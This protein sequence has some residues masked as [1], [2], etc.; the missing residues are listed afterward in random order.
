MNSEEPPQISL[1]W[2]ISLWIAA[3]LIATIATVGGWVELLIY[4]WIFPWGLLALFVP[5]DWDPP[6][7]DWL[8]LLMAWAL[9]VALTIIGLLQKRRVPYFIA[10]GILCAL[11][12]LNVAGCH[13]MFNRP[14]GPQH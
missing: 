14:I 1:R 12:A 10:F 6:V 8:I 9:Y 3:W 5:K 11:L 7:I 4:F 13:A 2:R